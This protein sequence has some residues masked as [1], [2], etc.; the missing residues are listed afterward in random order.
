MKHFIL[1]LIL[2]I[3]ALSG[4][5]QVKCHI[6]GKL[7]NTEFG[8][9]VIICATDVDIR[10]SNNYI[11]TKA[12]NNGHF[13]CDVESNQIAL[14]DVSLKEERDQGSWRFVNFLVENNATV[15]L[16]FNGDSWQVI[17]G[18]EEQTKKIKMDA[19]KERLFRA[20]ME[21]I[22]KQ[23]E[24][25]LRPRAEELTKQGKN[26]TDDTLLVKRSK[27]LEAEYNILY[28]EF[29]AWEID[30]YTKNPMLYPLYDIANVMQ[31]SNDIPQFDEI[32]TQNMHLYHSIYENYKPENPIHNTIKMLEAAW[33]LTPGKPYIDFEV[34]TV[35]GKRINIEPLY[36]GKV[37][38]I[39]FWA[40]WCGP[41]RRHSIDLIPIYEKYKDKGFT[42]I[43]IAHEEKLSDM[44]RAIA[45]DGY[46][47]QNYIDLNDKLKVWLKNGLG[48]GG[49]GM[50]LVD[51]NGIILSSSTN[52]DELEPLI[53][54]ALGL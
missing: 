41:C 17:N 36:R 40:S 29:K 18:G 28:N 46:P 44:T 15:T 22:Q 54:K 38:V 31:F 13:A 10:T 11:T 23:R 48:L 33:K 1:T 8:N 26:P 16:N 49:G 5:A 47:W 32:K 52:V 21:A 50:Y 12:D 7:S 20:K 2:A 3:A 25:E 39:D 6:E 43:G 24:E 34:E 14:Y 37:A 45:K 30:Y 4:Q 9:T 19:E 27:E 35:D 42:V 53:R 51:N